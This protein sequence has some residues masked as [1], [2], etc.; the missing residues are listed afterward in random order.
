MYSGERNYFHPFPL[1][2]PSCSILLGVI[3]LA[4]ER[5]GTPMIYDLIEVS[6]TVFSKDS[7]FANQQIRYYFHK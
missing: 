2:P 1:I 5:L 3:Q 7:T 6:V 4:M